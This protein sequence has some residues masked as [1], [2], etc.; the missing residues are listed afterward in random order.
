M[1]IRRWIIVLESFFMTSY[2]TMQKILSFMPTK[3]HYEYAK[4]TF[5]DSR[6]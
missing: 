3:N 2:Y 5:K 1:N 6:L 4:S